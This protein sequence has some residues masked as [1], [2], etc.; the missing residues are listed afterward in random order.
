MS[1]DIK[2]LLPKLGESIHSA[3][4][5]QWFKKIGD[6][7]KLDE[8]LLEVS[9]DKVNS[10][11]PSPAAGILKEI[12]AAPDLE[13]QV[14]ALIAVIELGAHEGMKEAPRASA[15]VS[16]TSVASE[17]SQEMKNFFSPALLRIARESNI[18]FE[19]LE[20]ISGTGMGGRLTKNDLEEYVEKKSAAPKTCPM[21]TKSVT[22]SAG[23]DVERL[24][25]TG[26]RKAIADN[27]V[28]SFYE[29]PHATLV[30]E[31]DVTDVIKQIQKEKEAF[32]AKHGFKLTITA[33][34]ARA[35]TKALLEYPLINSSLEGDT[36]LVKRYVNLGIAVSVDQGLMVPVVKHC[37]HMDITAI[38]KAIGEVSSKART[39]KLAPDDVTDG[40]MTITNFGMS[41][42]QIGI[43]I[44]RYPEV[45]IVGVGAAYKRVVPLEDDLLAIRT[46][47]NVSVTFDHRVLDGMYGCGFLSAVKKHLEADLA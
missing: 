33:F 9:T 8:P 44:I 22:P 46:L 47:M 23:T 30:T 16:V 12:H 1:E 13:L 26:M 6:P 39:G 10:E 37:Q 45:A 40:T 20:K 43:P 34:V 42:V 19:E 27:M 29:A 18:G 36:I 5:V 32:L 17:Q 31:V 2:V 15:A 3:T 41:G 28:R 14:G 38:A 35:I 21:A 11:I 7:V 25:M 24:K 4:I